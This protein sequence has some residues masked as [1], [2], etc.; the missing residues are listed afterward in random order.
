[1]LIL[2]LVSTAI[3][4][5]EPVTIV[6]DRAIVHVRLA[7]YDVEKARGLKKLRRRMVRAAAKVCDA[8]IPGAMQAELSACTRDTLAAGQ[9]QLD[10][11]LAH[12][13]PGSPRLAAITLKPAIDSK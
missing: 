13:W 11:I 2:L 9:R 4:A 7:D 8:A 6:G 10:A 12:D 3:S 5:G 1:M